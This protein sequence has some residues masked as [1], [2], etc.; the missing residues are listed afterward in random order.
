MLGTWLINLENYDIASKEYPIFLK[1]TVVKNYARSN[2]V[3][4]VKTVELNK[5][6]N[7]VTI[8]ALKSN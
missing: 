2:E 4:E 1:Y 7:K 3:R 6:L 8:G 5:L